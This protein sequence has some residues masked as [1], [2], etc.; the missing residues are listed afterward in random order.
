MKQLFL[1]IL[2]VIS[3]IIVGC[4]SQN[5]LAKTT[6]NSSIDQ[7]VD[8]IL[9]LM[10]LKEKAG[11]M[12]NIGLPAVLTGDYWDSRESTVYNSEKF[13]QLII[14]YA[15]GSIHN[16]PGYP[17]EKEGWYEILKKIQ[18]SAMQKTRLGIPV[19]YGIDN[20]HGANYVN[21]SVMFPHQIA[22]AATWNTELTKISAEITS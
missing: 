4:K 7:K 19:L 13:K 18:D 9:A 20:I 16:T 22:M 8:S 10:T 15:V 1:S 11:Q 14:D 5:K 3:L 2:L 12:L 21:G 17:A 6:H